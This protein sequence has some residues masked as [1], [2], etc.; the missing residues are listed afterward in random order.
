MNEEELQ[1]IRER[2][3][4]LEEREREKRHDL[5]QLFR[6]QGDLDDSLMAAWKTAT[7]G[8]ILPGLWILVHAARFAEKNAEGV[9]AQTVVGIAG[10]TVMYFFVPIATGFAAHFWFRNSL[11]ST[12]TM[13]AAFTLLSDVI[14]LGWVVVFIRW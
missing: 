9:I 10:L 8:L 7:L 5:R 2:E 13:A 6:D 1:R 14:F 3:L 12:R 11:V 4:E